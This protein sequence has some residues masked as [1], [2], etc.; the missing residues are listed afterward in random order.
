MSGKGGIDQTT[1]TIMPKT[2]KISLEKEQHQEA[3][4]KI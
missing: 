2:K 3:R 1:T 4:R